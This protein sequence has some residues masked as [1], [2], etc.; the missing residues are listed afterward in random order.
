[1][2]GMGL[3]DEIPS[4]GVVVDSLLRA[5][6]V[7]AVSV[8]EYQG[9]VFLHELHLANGMVIHLAAGTKGAQVLKITKEAAHG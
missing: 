7:L 9:K 2:N 6:N 1:M 5:N 4:S 8:E 3:P